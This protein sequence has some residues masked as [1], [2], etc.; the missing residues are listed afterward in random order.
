MRNLMR[1]MIVNTSSVYGIGI[2]QL[3]RPCSQKIGTTRS[4][5]T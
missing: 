2:D 4:H 3:E 5:H 1:L